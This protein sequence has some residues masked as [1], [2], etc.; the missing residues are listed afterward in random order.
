MRWTR[1]MCVPL[2]PA[3]CNF[4]L[5]IC[6][7]GNFQ[8]LHMQCSMHCGESAP[9]QGH[10]AASDNRKGCANLF[11]CASLTAAKVQAP[12]EREIA[13][14]EARIHAQLATGAGAA[15]QQAGGQHAGPE[16]R[17]A[18]TL[19]QQLGQAPDAQQ[20]AW[21][22]QPD[23][24][25]LASL[26]GKLAGAFQQ[27]QVS[28]G[29]GMGTP[30]A[31]PAGRVQTPEPQDALQL[32]IQQSVERAVKEVQHKLDELSER[33]AHMTLDHPKCNEALGLMQTCVITLNL[34]ASSRPP[35]ITLA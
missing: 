7:G 23:D 12:W 29:G 18:L 5:R 13:E 4:S 17:P 10:H 33:L 34:L 16:E 15:A 22:A 21:N 11:G 8:Q 35:P 6:S 24:D 14:Q 9:A 25:P 2:E 28:S 19:A 27:G 30:G 31:G 20:P 1:F 26:F 3:C 32:G